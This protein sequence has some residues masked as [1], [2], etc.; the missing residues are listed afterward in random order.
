[1]TFQHENKKYKNKYNIQ[2]VPLGGGLEL[3]HIL[4]HKYVALKDKTNIYS[5]CFL[6][7][8]VRFKILKLTAILPQWVCAPKGV[9]WHSM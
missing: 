1:M 4:S 6:F 9:K 8:L 2:K 3:I 7:I 5:H